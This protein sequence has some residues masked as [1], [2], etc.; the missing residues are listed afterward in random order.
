MSLCVG[1]THKY[2]FNSNEINTIQVRNFD[3]KF[4][5]VYA[6]ENNISNLKIKQYFRS[7]CFLIL[8]CERK[9]VLH[10]YLSE[11]SSQQNH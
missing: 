2:Y 10:I 8:T 3:C 5:Q 11:L 9:P 4:T 7:L 1:E 6:E